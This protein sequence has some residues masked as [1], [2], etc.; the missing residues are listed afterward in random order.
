MRMP[1]SS[2]LARNSAAIHRSPTA[3]NVV[4]R[5]QQGNAP[6]HPGHDAPLLHQAS[7]LAVRSIGREAQ[8]F[9]ACSPSRLAACRESPAIPRSRA[10]LA[11]PQASRTCG[12]QDLRLRLPVPRCPLTRL[13]R[14]SRAQVQAITVASYHMAAPPHLRRAC[15][16]QRQHL[17]LNLVRGLRSKAAERRA[18]G[19]KAQQIS[20]PLRRQPTQ[21]RNAQTGSPSAAATM[22]G[23]R[24]FIEQRCALC[25][26]VGATHGAR[27]E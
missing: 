8:R 26:V 19:S 6:A 11:G 25:E 13:I 24:Q 21:D 23:P 18:G 10:H 15:R 14:Q 2:A 20:H 16:Q 1:D 12:Q 7:Q 4:R 9:P 17:R 27:G 22:V 5:E 3:T